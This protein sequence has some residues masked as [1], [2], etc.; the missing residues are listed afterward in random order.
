[1]LAIVKAKCALSARMAVSPYQLLNDH[2]IIIK[3]I[4]GVYNL[5]Y[6]TQKL[7][8]EC[9][10]N[11]IFRNFKNCWSNGELLD[12]VLRQKPVI[13][14]LLL[15]GWRKQ[16]L[17]TFHI[18]QMIINNISVSFVS[19]QPPKHSRNWSKLDTLSIPIWPLCCLCRE[20]LSWRSNRAD[21]RQLIITCGRP[22]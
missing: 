5:K 2:L 12:K 18:D 14:L 15:G 4:T 7:S 8:L 10:V 6:L 22:Y 3:F 17:S 21:H 16:T 11:I 19:T 13:F 20:F 9:D 1:M